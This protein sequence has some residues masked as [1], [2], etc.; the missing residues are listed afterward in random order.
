[1]NSRI[2]LRKHRYCGEIRYRCPSENSSNSEILNQLP[3][4]SACRA[5]T[6]STKTPSTFNLFNLKTLK[7]QTPCCHHT[8][9]LK[10]GPHNRRAREGDGA[11]EGGREGRRQSEGGRY[12]GRD[13]G[14][15][16]RR[17]TEPDSHTDRD[18]I[19]A[20][21]LRERQNIGWKIG[22]ETK[23]WLA[24]ADMESIYIRHTH[25]YKG[26]GIYIR[27]THTYEA[28]TSLHATRHTHA[29]ARR[30]KV[31]VGRRGHFRHEDQ[32]PRGQSRH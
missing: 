12:R 3:L 31:A 9:S 1:M 30:A 21:R 22:R 14:R 11:R 7:L 23:Y 27:H 10:H 2:S 4:P 32:A 29:H 25:A 19:V 6:P 24:G 28:Y 17:E 5:R 18:K 26:K 16:R 8:H 15:D 13:R 20:R